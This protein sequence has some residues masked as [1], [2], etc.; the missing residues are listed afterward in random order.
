MQT[1]P[2]QP[3]D[4]RWGRAFFQ[5]VDRID[6]AEYVSY[7]TEDGQVV[8]GNQPPISGKADIQKSMQQFYN[9]L[10]AMHH[11][12]ESLWA[13]AD[14]VISQAIAHYTRQDGKTVDLPVV[15]VINLLGDK[16]QFYMDINPL[17][18]Q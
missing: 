8:F 2:Q 9:S 17:Y 7:F 12:I 11:Q 15:T 18:A 6:A 3:I 13:L 16:V 1:Q 14:T 4:E 10:S 5:M